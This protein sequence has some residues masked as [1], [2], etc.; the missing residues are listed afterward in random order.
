MASL[1]EVL[2][3][4][5]HTPFWKCI[6]DYIPSAQASR[7]WWYTCVLSAKSLLCMCT[8]FVCIYLQA[9]P[10]VSFIF[11][12]LNV[13]LISFSAGKWSIPTVTGHRPPPCTYF[14]FTAISDHLAVLFGGDQPGHGGHV[15]H[16]YVMNFNT[17]V[18]TEVFCGVQVL[19]L[20]ATLEIIAHSVVV[21][22]KWNLQLPFTNCS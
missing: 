14:S 5:G 6:L 4:G 20:H 15:N 1:H 17:M 19:A 12:K 8:Y 16:C 13:C 18:C 2:N 3:T 21:R 22:T 9:L 7:A 10:I 11:S